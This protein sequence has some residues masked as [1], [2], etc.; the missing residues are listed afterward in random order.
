M[1]LA[2]YCA[3]AVYPRSSTTGYDRATGK[4]ERIE[5]LDHLNR[6][7]ELLT[8]MRDPAH[9]VTIEDLITY[10]G[11]KVAAMGPEEGSHKQGRAPL[12]GDQASW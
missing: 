8:I 12:G 6:C 2:G 7:R 4:D 9:R 5:L 1:P 3:D 11:S 10:L